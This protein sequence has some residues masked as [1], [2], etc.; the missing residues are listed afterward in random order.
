MQISGSNPDLAGVTAHSPRRFDFHLPGHRI[1]GA[2]ISWA[3]VV[4]L[5]LQKIDLLLR[6]GLFNGNM[7]IHPH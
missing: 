7:G 5:N 3:R 1:N 2:Q 4:S 6:Y